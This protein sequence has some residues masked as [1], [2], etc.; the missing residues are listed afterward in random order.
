MRP[1]PYFEPS[2]RA[3]VD[4]TRPYL[5]SIVV[6]SPAMEY[7]YIGKGSSPSR[8]NAYRRNVERVLEG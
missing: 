2:N 7:R 4:L 1:R 6:N 3:G 5:Y 8:M